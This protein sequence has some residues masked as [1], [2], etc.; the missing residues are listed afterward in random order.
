ML[1]ESL[2]KSLDKQQ[3]AE[4]KYNKA[5]I[6]IKKKDYRAAMDNAWSAKELYGDSGNS[7]KMEESYI[8]FDHAAQ[9]ECDR[10]NGYCY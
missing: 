1:N 6:Y 7:K 8:L 4:A 10:P 9:L 3:V 2:K 5:K